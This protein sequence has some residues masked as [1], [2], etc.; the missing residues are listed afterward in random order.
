MKKLWKRNQIMITA[1][2]LMIAVAGYLN[3]M[4][5]Q[6]DKEDLFT[7][8]AQFEEAGELTDDAMTADGSANDLSDVGDTSMAK[9]EDVTTGDGLA[10]ISE[11]TGEYDA[12]TDIDSMDSEEEMVYSDYLD[13]E[14]AEA[15]GDEPD[16]TQGEAKM[17]TDTAHADSVLQTQ[18][19]DN[20]TA[21][22]SLTTTGADDMTAAVTEDYDGEVPGEAVFTSGMTISS[23]ESAN[24]L[25]EQTREKNKEM[26]LEIINSDTVSDSAKQS[27]VDSMITLT[28]IAQKE[29]A[30]Q[31]LLEAKGFENVVVSISQNQADVIVGGTSLDEAQRAQIEDIVSRKTGI[32]VENIII[33]PVK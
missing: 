7:T 17:V 29:C 12:L 28:D 9:I 2:A 15:V 33:S 5:K 18:G 24:L 13:E 26:L 30:A 21:D 31:I 16:A 27:A 25:K 20:T 22:A 4:G 14:T 8:S 10:L 11:E 1:L 32:D 6:V 23:I 19:A 3:F